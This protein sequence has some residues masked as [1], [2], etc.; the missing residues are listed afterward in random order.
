MIC[1]RC[2]SHVAVLP[3]CWPEW[4]DGRYL[5]R[6]ASLCRACIATIDRAA[7]GREWDLE[8]VDERWVGR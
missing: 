4:V 6:K 5:C 3:Y 2:G 8:D 7:E 1:A